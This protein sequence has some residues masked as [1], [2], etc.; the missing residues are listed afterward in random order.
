[1]GKQTRDLAHFCR[2]TALYLLRHGAAALQELAAAYRKN[3]SLVYS[4]MQWAD[5]KRFFQ[6]GGGS[7]GIEYRLRRELQ[8]LTP[9]ELYQYINT[10]YK[11]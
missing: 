3:A 7:G 4:W 11:D 6:A 2:L 9:A 10:Y 8:G 1:M 5:G